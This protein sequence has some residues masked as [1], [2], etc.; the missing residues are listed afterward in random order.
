M[1]DA[2]YH[3]VRLYFRSGKRPRILKRGLTLAQVQAHCGNPETS[4]NT[5]K[6]ATARACTRRNGPWFDAYDAD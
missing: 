6:G 3:I 1:S 2:T 4:S 5:A